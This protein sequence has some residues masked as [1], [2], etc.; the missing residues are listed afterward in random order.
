MTI[1][2]NFFSDDDNAEN[3]INGFDIPDSDEAEKDNV[4][5]NQFEMFFSDTDKDRKAKIPDSFQDPFELA[6]FAVRVLDSKKA[7]GIKLLR[8]SEK[9]VIADYFIL[10]TG[11]SNTQLRALSGELEE[12]LRKSGIEPG[13]IEGY[14]EASWIIMDY[15][16]VI[17]HIFNRE[18]RIFYNL[19]KLWS[20]AEEIDISG[21]ID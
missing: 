7:R 14:N 5:D 9:T 20:E 10:C 3:E 8:V 11:T 4:S 19:E 6:K 21:F 1:E 13:H 16:S 12:E 2:K 15:A 18:T 17:V